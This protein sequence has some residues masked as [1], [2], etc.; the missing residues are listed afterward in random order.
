MGRF[1]GIDYGKRRIGLALSDPLGMFATGF[2]TLDNTGPKHVFKA[3]MAIIADQDIEGIVIGM[4]YRTTGEPGDTA[5][6]INDFTEQLKT[7]TALPIVFEDERFTS[8]IAQQSLTAQGVK[9]SKNKGL[10]D[11]TAA[12]LILQQ[13][14][15]KRRG[16]IG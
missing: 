10:V 3:L 6:E 8:V 13:F 7:H 16:P 14:L 2:E 5:D 4:S 1:L 12:A 11:K 15:D 9:H